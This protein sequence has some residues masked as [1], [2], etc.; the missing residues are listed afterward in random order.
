MNA[1]RGIIVFDLDG[2]LTVPMLDFDAIRAEIGICD[3]PILE[4]VA[5]MDDSRK[6]AAESI[7][8]RH[9]RH[10]AENVEP[11]PGAAR[12]VASL[13][14]SG[15]PVAILTR[16]ATR[17]A[18]LALERLGI[19]VDALRTRDDGVIKPSPVAIRQLCEQLGGDPAQSWMIGDHWFDIETGRRAGCRT[20][21]MIGD[22]PPPAYA[23][24]AHHVICKLSEIIDIIEA[25]DRT[26]R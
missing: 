14:E 16:N 5:Q 2:T 15:W 23:D 22:G 13:R 19:E 7:L 12:C 3:G 8:E 4:A 21:L 6:P 9:E 26:A 25:P 11:Q 20:V 10:A 24:Q 17:W 18:Q 1:S